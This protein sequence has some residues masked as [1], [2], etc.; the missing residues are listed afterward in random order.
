LRVENADI[1]KRLLEGELKPGVAAIAIQSLN[2]DIRAVDVSM[3]A[4]EQEELIARIEEV[5]GA[6]EGE[7][8]RYGT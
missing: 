7:G 1:R 5:D 4:K 3:K 8:R 2:T 6:M